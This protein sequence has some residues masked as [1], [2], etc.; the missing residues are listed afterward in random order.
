MEQN[1]KKAK[2]VILSESEI[3]TQLQSLP[4]WAYKDNKLSKK[5]EFKS[6]IEGLQF[7]NALAPYFEK[8]DHHADM[9]I[10]YKKI[11]FELTRYD[12]GGKVTDGDIRVAKEIESRYQ[13][14]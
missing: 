10:Y 6:F 13:A 9:H 8:N 2:P 11:I 1:N 14:L 12:V 3:T 5:Y 7:I 4:G